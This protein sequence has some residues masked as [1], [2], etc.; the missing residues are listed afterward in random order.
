ML[1][2]CRK[3]VTQDIK[4]ISITPRALS[5]YNAYIQKFLKRTVWTSDCR[6]WYKNSKI[7]GKITII[8]VVSIFHYQTCLEE[9]RTEDFEYEYRDRNSFKWIGN[10]I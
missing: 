1:R 10:G 5:D 7:D 2:W 3:I 4:S 6:S 9:F 8:Y